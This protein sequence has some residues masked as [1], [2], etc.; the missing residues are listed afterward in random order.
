[1]AGFQ[2]ILRGMT[3]GGGKGGPAPRTDL[4]AYSEKDSRLLKKVS[5][6]LE[7]INDAVKSS[8]KNWNKM[9]DARSLSRAQKA[10]KALK[11]ENQAFDKVMKD[12]NSTIE[13]R[14][15][16]YNKLAKAQQKSKEEVNE[17]NREMNEHRGILGRTRNVLNDLSKNKGMALLAAGIRDFTIAAKA[18]NESLDIMARSGQLTD[19]TFSGLAKST[20][21]MAF[22]MK[23]AMIQ[24]VA[25]GISAD[26]ANKA[27]VNLTD[28]FGG[29]VGVANMLRE[30]WNEMAKVARKSG[31]SMAEMTNIAAQGYKR[32]GEDLNDSM[33]NVVRMAK[34]T[35]NLNRQFGKGSVN[36]RDYAKAVNTLAFS[37]GFYN[38]STRL[39]IESLGREIQTQLALGRSRE[40]AVEGATKNLQVAGK[41]NLLGFQHF[42]QEMVA[43]YDKAVAEN[44]TEEHIAEL[45]ERFG[46]Q[47][48]VIAHMLERGTLL[49][50]TNLFAFKDLVSE[51]SALQS[52]MLEMFRTTGRMED[53]LAYGI[54]LEAASRM[55]VE[56]EML[57]DQLRAV[58]K[59]AGDEALRTL[60]KLKP[61]QPV[62]PEM[63]G[64]ATELRKGDMTDE[65]M[66]SKLRSLGGRIG[67]IAGEAI[68][69]GKKDWRA[70]VDG[71]GLGWFAGITGILNTIAASIK[72]LPSGIVGV[73]GG[74]A[75]A[76]AVGVG[77][78][79]GA[80]AAGAGAAG[81]LKTGAGAAARLALP[82]AAAATV[83]AMFTNMMSSFDETVRLFGESAD[84]KKLVGM[85]AVGML[86]SI[87]FWDRDYTD[88]EKK[89][90]VTGQRKSFLTSY[91][92]YLF[93]RPGMQEYREE[94]MDRASR[95]ARGM[96]TE[97]I[98]A[99]KAAGVAIPSTRGGDE[100]P[101]SAAPDPAPG[102]AASAVGSL[103]Q[104]NLILE[105]TN[106]ENVLAESQHN[107]A[108]NIG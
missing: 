27:F 59:G 43:E 78:L 9:G 5:K 93:D 25:M 74:L 4:P 44:R 28:T 58:Q 84:A 1:M 81:A 23:Y 90:I 70:Y 69:V 32:L 54:G 82:V 3:G 30:N 76:K 103:Q 40:A 51:S 92:D 72:E 41:T 49:S 73:L 83:G 62:T 86:D 65:Q 7:N 57:V 99:D 100:A 95:R 12:S 42:A 85:W 24:A 96:V 64:F 17:A 105:V 104:G 14:V 77:P 75:L 71:G 89:G 68:E 60:F 107:M 6:D 2:D 11:E 98:R 33:N 13:D 36:T 8:A 16:A 22:E 47:G 56:R 79:A 31:L 80:G 55:K 45:T 52:H 106:W 10:L 53:M 37:Q 66:L 102:G 34:V 97:K 50:E 29:T 39:V 35:A 15:E 67:G 20:G 91:A 18:M 38:Q 19:T 94:E 108:A 48:E 46:S 61:E 101:V 21:L 87:S 26:D 88:E 63:R